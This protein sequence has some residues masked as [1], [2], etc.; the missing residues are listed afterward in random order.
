MQKTHIRKIGN[1]MPG[2]LNS[3]LQIIDIL[4]EQIKTHNFLWERIWVLAESISVMGKRKG[5]ELEK[6][7][8]N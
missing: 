4:S 5:R 7:I 6:N 2:T 3:I 1:S 8:D